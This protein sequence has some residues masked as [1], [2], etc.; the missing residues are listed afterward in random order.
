LRCSYSVPP[1]ALSKVRS[2]VGTVSSH[3]S[4]VIG[5]APIPS[6]NAYARAAGEGSVIGVGAETLVQGGRR[7]FGAAC[8]G[9]LVP[10][11]PLPPDTGMGHLSS[12]C[13]Q[14]G[15]SRRKKQEKKFSGLNAATRNL[16]RC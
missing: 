13:G 2:L 1:W 11:Y 5:I 6:A 3:A 9:P 4:V 7:S 16:T 10:S 15:R 8:G 12:R 14:D